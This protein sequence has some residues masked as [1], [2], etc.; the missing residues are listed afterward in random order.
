MHAELHAE[1]IRSKFKCRALR[2]VMHNKVQQPALRVPREFIALFDDAHWHQ[3]D[4][5]DVAHASAKNFF[6]LL[7]A[8]HRKHVGALREHRREMQ[9]SKPIRVRFHDWAERAIHPN[10]TTQH[11][12]IVRDGRSVE[13]KK[14]R[15]LHKSCQES[16]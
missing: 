3:Y 14:T 6:C 11:A 1:R 7:G 9:R 8:V 16:Q 5:R 15:V 2:C 4:N 10:N 12:E 13:F